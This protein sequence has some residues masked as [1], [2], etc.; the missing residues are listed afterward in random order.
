MDAQNKNIGKITQVI[1]A[2]VDVKFAETSIPSIYN[3]LNATV[4]IDGKVYFTAQTEVN[5]GEWYKVKIEKA[6]AYDLYGGVIDEF[7]E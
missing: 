2:V 7:T 5:Q 3:A 4:E 1:G 6:D